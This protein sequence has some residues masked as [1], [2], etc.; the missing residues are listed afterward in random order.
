MLLAFVTA[1][2]LAT[3]MW[4]VP[5]TV[6][7]PGGIHRRF[8]RPRDIAW[9]DVVDLTEVRMWWCFGRVTVRVKGGKTLRLDGIPPNALPD[10]RTFA[11]GAIAAQTG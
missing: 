8:G 9:E 6:I 4:F 1:V 2:A 7:D 3:A 10:V 5:T 11:Q